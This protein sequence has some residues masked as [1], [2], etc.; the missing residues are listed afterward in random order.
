M[1]LINTTQNTTLAT[2][3]VKARS[4]YARLMGLMG[5]HQLPPGEALWIPGCTSIHTCFMRFHLDVV[6]V[7]KNFKVVALYPNLKPWRLTKWHRGASGVFELPT[8][9]A[10]LKAQKGDTLYVET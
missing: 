3:L 5:R 10:P 2:R 4:F 6:F 8:Q 9:T 1:K 7:D